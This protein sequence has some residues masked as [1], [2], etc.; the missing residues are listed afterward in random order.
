MAGSISWE[1][2]EYDSGNVY[3]GEYGDDSPHGKG[4]MIY[5]D[6]SVYEGEW[7]DGEFVGA[8]GSSKADENVI[9]VIDAVTFQE[10]GAIFA[11]GKN[12]SAAVKR[13]EEVLLVGNKIN[14]KVIIDHL[15][16]VH[17]K[18]GPVL[19]CTPYRSCICP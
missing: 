8:S 6:G 5:A 13:D 14:T 18:D 3:E 15:V 10:S 16:V 2:I 11:K 1:R 7:E 9:M 17:K 19:D 4:K 12:I